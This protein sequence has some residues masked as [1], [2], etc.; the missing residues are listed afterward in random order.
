MRTVIR[1]SMIGCMV[2]AFI[3][4]TAPLGQTQTLCEKCGVATQISKCPPG[5][6]KA[7]CPD[8][9]DFVRPDWSLDFSPSTQETK[10]PETLCAKCGAATPIAKCPPGVTKA[11][12]ADMK[13][14]VRPT[15]GFDVSPAEDSNLYAVS[16]A[17]SADGVHGENTVCPKCGQAFPIDRRIKALAN[18][19]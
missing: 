10:T 15:R 6:P 8:M 3:C 16:P 1:A 18:Q 5:V 13:D 9:K 2:L 11:D 7:S 4:M 12:C 17:W 14:F 19:P